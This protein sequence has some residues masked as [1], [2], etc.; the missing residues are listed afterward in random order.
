[1]SATEDVEYYLDVEASDEEDN[2]PF[3]FN[4]TFTD[5]IKAPWNISDDC[6][7]FSINNSTGEINFTPD[8]WDVGNYTINFTVRDS[9]NTEEPYNATGYKLV[10]FMVINVNDLPN[11]TSISNQT[12][13]QND[14][15]NI[16][17]NATDIENDTLTFNTTTL[18]LNLSVYDNSSLFPI[19]TDSSSYPSKPTYGKMNYTITNN[20][21]GNYT[22]NITLTDGS[23]IIYQL[24]NFTIYNVNDP[25][26][27][28]PIENQTAIQEE[29]FYYDVN[30]SDP[31]QLTPYGD[32]ITYNISFIECTKKFK[33]GDTNCSI[34]GIDNQT[35][36]ISFTPERN[37]S[38]N[39]TLNIS[40]MDSGGLVDWKKV[41]LT[42]VDD[43]APNVTS[44]GAQITTQNQSFYLEINATDYENNSLVF[45]SITY[46][47]NLTEHP[48]TSLF[49][50]YTNNSSYPTEPT[51]GIM[52]YTRITNNQ[53]GNYTVKIIV[54]DTW[55]RES[56][57]YI[58]FTVYNVNDPPNIT[59]IPDQDWL[60]DDNFY[61]D[62]NATDIDMDTP[63]GDNLTFSDNT[64]LFNISKTTGVIN[65]TPYND[66]FAGFYVIN[67]TVKDSNNSMDFTV[68]TMNITAVNDAPEIINLSD[69]LNA[70]ENNTFYNVF[71]A[72]DEEN[73][74]PFYFNV[75]FLNC[76]NGYGENVNCKL[77]DIIQLSN[78]SFE[79]NFTPNASYVGNY[80]INFTV[81][82]SGNTTDPHNAT[83]WKL[84]NFTVRSLN[85]PPETSG[86]YAYNSTGFRI[87]SSTNITTGCQSLSNN[88]SEK[89]GDTMH[90]Y[91][92]NITD[93]NNDDLEC[94]WY[95]ITPGN[96][97][98]LTDPADCTTD[99][100][101]PY[102]PSF[103]ASGINNGTHNITLK[104]TEK[105]T[106]EKYF[107]TVVFIVNVSNTNRAPYLRI[108]IQNQTWNMNTQNKNIHLDVNFEDP[109]NK[110]DVTDDDNVLIFNT[111]SLTHISLFIDNQTH[112]VT[113]IP[114]KDWYGTEYIMFTVTDGEFYVNS[115]NVT[116]NVTYAESEKQTITQTV[117]SGGGGGGGAATKETK[118][119]SLSI[120]TEKMVEMVS[121]RTIVPITLE[122][123]GEVVLNGIDLYAETDDKNELQLELNRTYIS[124]MD[125]KE[126]MKI[127]LAII[128]KGEPTKEIYIIQFTGSVSDPEFNQT[129]LIYIRSL[130]SN[131]TVVEKTIKF[132]KDLFQENPE[133]LDLT[134]LIVQ[135]ETELKKDNL[136][137]ARHLTELAV[138]NC[139]DM[140]LYKQNMTRSPLP[141]EE[142]YP[143]KWIVLLVVFVV[144]GAG[145]YYYKIERERTRRIKMEKK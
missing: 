133:C 141:Q 5:C 115:N 108:P 81:R 24:V 85:Y 78:T 91:V 83:R 86:W 104:I 41:N 19:E 35:G 134:E 42:V 51:K 130:P 73:N 61:Y 145:F 11:M 4:V 62:V 47:R 16:I 38:G 116:L 122:N 127:E 124:Q 22:L 43:Y 112:I 88:I 77:F 123:T 95:D 90:I 102:S 28:D 30:A 39:Y 80:T 74:T 46:Y 79:I 96:T 21:V 119:A 129:N 27:L 50:I 135:A 2:T 110:N 113:L 15:L 53:V 132:A 45:G 52:N 26:V 12:I 57:I 67:V 93:P 97:D 98:T 59:Q 8:N 107:A 48:N 64:T 7:L 144:A 55:G 66:S 23:A 94:A 49:T 25:P 82:D 111:S 126:K 37:D 99:V 118:I 109:D 9:G 32:V 68:F 89:E 1:M 6:V 143:I 18:L 84:V 3:Y 13:Y 70:I 131:R 121:N 56:Y 31:D 36:V 58:N 20:Q 60:E 140:I 103:D 105:N 65:F 137:K 125:V 29:L 120:T 44:V 10:T 117:S 63:Y 114:E 128:N 87:C 106:V 76:S 100:M 101:L 136:E 75:T 54:N 71:N 69:K 33:P 14:V 40:V 139:K 138:K 17:I 142:T 34:F 72:T 92:K